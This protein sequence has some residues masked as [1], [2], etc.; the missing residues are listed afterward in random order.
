MLLERRAKV[1]AKAKNGATAL[2]T[3]SYMGHQEI[4]RALLRKGARANMSDNNGM[5]PADYARTGGHEEVVE[6]LSRVRRDGVCR[7]TQAPHLTRAFKR[8]WRRS[9]S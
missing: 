8:R 5:S 9:Y 1:N 3:A 4:F 7:H 2:C 6:I